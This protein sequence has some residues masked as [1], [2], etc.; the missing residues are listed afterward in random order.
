MISDYCCEVSSSQSKDFLAFSKGNRFSHLAALCRFKIIQIAFTTWP[1][2]WRNYGE[3]LSSTA[4]F[5][6]ALS[7]LLQPL[8]CYFRELLQAFTRAELQ[9]PP[10]SFS[11]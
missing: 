1:S 6:C 9:L 11:A 7:Q 5:L 2:R 8:L 10:E 3:E 4:L